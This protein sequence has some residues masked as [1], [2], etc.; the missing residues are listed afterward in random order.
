M[1]NAS[2]LPVSKL[3]VRLHIEAG[4]QKRDLERTI[5]LEGGATASVVFP[6]EKLSEG[7]GAGTSRRRSAMTYRSTTAAFWPSRSL[8]RP[9]S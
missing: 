4:D 3:P 6:L 5:D 8:R 2:P 1:F 9:G 7:S